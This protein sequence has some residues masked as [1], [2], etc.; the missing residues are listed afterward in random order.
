MAHIMLH[1]AYIYYSPQWMHASH[2]KVI[3]FSGSFHR[4]MHGGER[5]I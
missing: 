4:R 1:V 2:P 5:T 3:A